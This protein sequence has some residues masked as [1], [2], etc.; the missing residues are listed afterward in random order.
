MRIRIAFGRQQMVE[1]DAVLERGRG[2][3]CPECWRAPSRIGTKSIDI[4]L[5]EIDQRQHLRRDPQCC[6]A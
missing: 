3:R 4:L 1:Q 2:H 6:R 5:R